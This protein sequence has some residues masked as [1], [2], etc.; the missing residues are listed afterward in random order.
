MTDNIFNRLHSVQRPSPQDQLPIVMADNPSRDFVFPTTSDRVL[1]RLAELPADD[2]D[3]ITHL[4]FRRTDLDRTDPQRFF[5]YIGGSGVQLIVIYPWPK[6]L[7]LRLGSSRP[8][9][10]TLNRYRPWTTD[11]R[12]VDRQWC[13]VWT[14]DSVE[15]FTL[16]SVI[17]T[18]VGYYDAW[19][20]HRWV[21]DGGKV[22]HAR[23]ESYAARWSVTG[24]EERT[25]SDEA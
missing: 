17:P 2:V 19:R 4:W 20:R 12:K 15:R 8:K 21:G 5:D 24:V 9:P 6:D 11:L 25:R 18:A 22:M 7:L 10:K 3:G 1:G 13:L 14:A 23:A 16:E